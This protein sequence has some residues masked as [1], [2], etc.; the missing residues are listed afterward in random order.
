[1]S[2]ASALEAAEMSLASVSAELDGER[3]A[4]SQ[5]KALLTDRAAEQVGFYL[6]CFYLS[7]LRAV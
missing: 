4:H 7:P 3:E 6:K 1:M 2:R 5:T